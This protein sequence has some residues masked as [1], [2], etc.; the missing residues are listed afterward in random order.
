MNKSQRHRIG[1]LILLVIHLCFGFVTAARATDEGP[2]APTV[3]F[4]NT[5]ERVLRSSTGKD[6]RL[7]ITTPS[8][9]APPGGWPVV[10]VVDGNAWFFP[11]AMQAQLRGRNPAHHGTLPVVVVGIGYP[12]ERL[13]NMQRRVYDMTPPAPVREAP[14]VPGGKEWPA[15]GGADEF[16]DFIETQVKPLIAAEYRINPNR[17]ALFGHSLGGLFTL[18]AF[19]TRP[20]SYQTFAAISPS[21]WW[22]A[23]F[24]LEERKTFDAKWAAAPVRPSLLM[25]VGSEELAHMV[26]DPE[27]LA[28]DLQPLVTKGLRMKYVKVPN[29][30]HIGVPLPAFTELLKFAYTPTAAEKAFYA[31]TAPA[32]TKAPVFTDPAVYLALTPAQRTQIRIDVRLMSREERAAYNKRMYD[33]IHHKMTAEQAELLHREKTR[34][35]RRNGTVTV[36]D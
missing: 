31:A 21:I 9:K 35:D 7:F 32:D 22:N 13:L 16:L 20:Q 15:P 5:E 30:D 27:A 23:K 10:Y 24:V 17:Q 26:A 29:E 11:A 8:Q 12:G 36:L 18:H 14:P 19:F 25:M 34:E 1:W 3:A 6:Y 33:L 28:A 4:P 2:L